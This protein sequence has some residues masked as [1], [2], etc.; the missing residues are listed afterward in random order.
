MSVK[1]IFVA[2]CLTA[3][4]AAAQEL[5]LTVVPWQPVVVYSAPPT[6]LFANASPIAAI[7]NQNGATATYALQATSDGS[8]AVGAATTAQPGELTVLDSQDVAQ[9]ETSK[10][11]LQIGLG[12][13]RGDTTGWILCGDTGAAAGNTSQ[14]CQNFQLKH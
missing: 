11:W 14:P 13:A 4:P 7:S 12:K 9:G 8:F 10:R 6:G 3:T 1:P 2:L 5:G